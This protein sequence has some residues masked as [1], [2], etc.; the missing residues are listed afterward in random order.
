MLFIVYGLDKDSGIFS[1][2][3]YHCLAFQLDLA[4]GGWQ[5]GIIT[6]V[7]RNVV[8]NL[9]FGIFGLLILAGCII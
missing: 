9:I 6:I 3:I 1:R 5:R 8:V 2:D 4:F 7:R